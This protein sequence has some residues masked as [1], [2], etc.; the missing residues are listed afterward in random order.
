MQQNPPLS[1]KASLMLV[2]LAFVLGQ[3]VVAPF[4]IGIP[5]NSATYEVIL[6]AAAMLVM[7]AVISW[8]YRSEFADNWP[9]AMGLRRPRLTKTDVAWISLLYLGLLLLFYVVWPLS[10]E[11]AGWVRDVAIQVPLPVILLCIVIIAPLGEELICRQCL[12]QGIKQRFG[13]PWLATSI[14]AVFWALLHVQYSP[15][16]WLFIFLAGL[17]LGWMRYRS[18]S[19][20]APVMLHTFHN[21][22]TLVLA[23]HS[24]GPYY[25]AIAIP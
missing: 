16:G 14:T 11:D 10:A 18:G 5:D 8:T 24:I 21:L 15:Q 1:L 9:R 12:W 25:L 19:L 4:A 22:L 13:S 17:L 3:I 23:Y 7:A 2:F 6:A 20:W